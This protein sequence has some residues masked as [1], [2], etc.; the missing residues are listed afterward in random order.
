MEALDKRRA[1]RR[2]SKRRAS[3]SS[4]LTRL[5]EDG[6]TS[7]VAYVTRPLNRKLSLSAAAAILRDT[8][9]GLYGRLLAVLSLQADGLRNRHAANAAIAARS[10]PAAAQANGSLEQPGAEPSASP[11]ITL[12]QRTRRQ[13]SRA[14]AQ[15]DIISRWRSHRL[16]ETATRKQLLQFL[17]DRQIHVHCS[18]KAALLARVA[19]VLSSEYPEGAPQF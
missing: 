9:P 8:I 16:R 18:T 2:A 19:E 12:P 5:Q 10:A 11:E 13:P 4:Q 6:T 1:D 14:A 17:Q 7:T 15:E 3:I